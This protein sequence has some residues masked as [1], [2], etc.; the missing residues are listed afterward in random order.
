MLNPL[1]IF[2]QVILPLALV[3]TAGFLGRRFLHLDPRPFSRVAL[4][5]LAPSVFFTSLM[6]SQIKAGEA[7]RIALIAL[8]LF[9][10]VAALSGGL[11]RLLRL[12]AQEQSAFILSSTLINT[13]N[14]GFPVV[15]LA[16]G[17][18][19]LERAALFAVCHASLANSAG[20]YI[21]ARGRSGGIRQAL[22][23]VLGIPMVYGVI[24][25]LLLRLV[26]FSFDGSLTL[27]GKELLLLTSIY[28]AVKLLA[29]G[30]VPVFSLVLGMQ[31][32]AEE[33]MRFSGPLLLAGAIRLLVS[34]ALA[35]GLTRLVGLQGLSAQTTILEAAM[36]TAVIGVILATEFEAHPR[37]VSTAVVGTT[38]LSMVTLT[39]LLSVMG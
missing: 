33:R 30:A 12:P 21:A 32:A 5:F 10:L 23:Q 17:E 34:P 9:G 35:W 28:R 25:A 1:R 2:V 24:L 37:F 20:V 19:G 6:E 16:L 14:Y 7:G 11:G 4:Y 31:L 27:H 26:G 8:L 36:P 3:W 18:A 38:L 15:L 29:Q 13:T 22:R 39:L